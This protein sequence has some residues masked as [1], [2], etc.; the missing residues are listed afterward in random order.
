MSEKLFEI[1]LRTKMRFPFKGLISTE[2]LYDLSVLNLDSVFKSLNS[3][4]KKVKEESLLDAK[5]QQDK[6]LETKIEIVKY[7]VQY[8]LDEETK[9]QKAKAQKEQKQK[10]LSILS[11]KQDASLQNKSI[12]EL[13]A[14]LDEL[15]S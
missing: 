10:I 7:I 4:L 3:E 11:E 9:R 5:S 2:D 15:N 12:E 1:A 14:M 6:D 13:T 8:K